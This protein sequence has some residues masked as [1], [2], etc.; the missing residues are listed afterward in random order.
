MDGAQV[1]A[2]FNAAISAQN[3]K[4][5]T[6]A[7]ERTAAAKAH[8][9]AQAAE[10]GLKDVAEEGDGKAL[11]PKLLPLLDK[12]NE[13]PSKPI[14][15]ATLFESIV[16]GW[17]DG[18]DPQ[19][20]TA[21]RRLP[22]WLANHEVQRVR[23]VFLTWLSSCRAFKESGEAGWTGAPEMPRY[24]PRGKLPSFG[25]SLVH[26]LYGS[27]LPTLTT[28]HGMR[29]GEDNLVGLSEEH[30]QAW[31]GFSLRPARPRAS[32]AWRLCSPAD[33]TRSCEAPGLSR[34]S[35]S[36]LLALGSWLLAE[37]IP[38]RAKP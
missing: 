4:R 23:G 16:R 17:A 24:F 35:C 8:A 32:H 11:E 37:M 12:R 14:L 7:K 18:L 25:R 38:E 34:P 6:K 10:N 33:P 30:R 31:N 22:S 2:A 15:D 27:R 5:S 29:L 19:G 36:R 21:Y 9:D 28:D 13:A 1:L 3:A 26:D 20:R